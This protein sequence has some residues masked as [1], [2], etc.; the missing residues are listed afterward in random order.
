MKI[1]KFKLTQSA[2]E[3]LLNIALFGMRRFGIKQS[4]EY[5]NQLLQRFQEIAEAPLLYPSVDYI[6]QGYR[7]SVC[8]SHSI[9]YRIQEDFI[10][11]MRIIGQESF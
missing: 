2:E 7:R 8:G 10:E 9:Y 4:E 5:K 11:I 6:R 3:D 1:A